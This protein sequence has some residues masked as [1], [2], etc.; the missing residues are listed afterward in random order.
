MRHIFLFLTLI[1]FLS[2]G[3][4][5]SLTEG[6]INAQKISEVVN[7]HNLTKATISTW[8]ISYYSYS[9]WQTRENNADFKIEGSFV[10]VNSNYYNLA[11]LD[12]FSY[13]EPILYVYLK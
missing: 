2:C 7:N 13:S 3:K 10:I 11:K 5:D 1:G 9:I 12:Y 4:D 6:E 8:E